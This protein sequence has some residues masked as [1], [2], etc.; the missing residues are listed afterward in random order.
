MVPS[1]DAESAR[2]QVWS[3]PSNMAILGRPLLLLFLAEV[4]EPETKTNPMEATVAKE[5]MVLNATKRHHVK[6]MVSVQLS[7]ETIPQI[8]I[9]SADGATTP[10]RWWHNATDQTLGASVFIFSL[11]GLSTK[12]NTPTCQV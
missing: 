9:L 1:I 2:L 10:I 7:S 4:M 5:S 12:K 6:S 3:I 11:E 8:S